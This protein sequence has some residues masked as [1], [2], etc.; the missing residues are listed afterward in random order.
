MDHPIVAVSDRGQ[1]TIPKSFRD[2]IPVKHFI[3]EMKDGAIVLRPLQTRAE[4]LEELEGADKKWEKHGGT[5][6]QK[7]MKKAKL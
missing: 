1:I 7:V 4:F 6:W 5:P 3:F 2:K